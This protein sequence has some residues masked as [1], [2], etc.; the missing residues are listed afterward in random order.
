[1]SCNVEHPSMKSLNH[2]ALA[3][4]DIFEYIIK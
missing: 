1:M 2:N 3:K 4:I